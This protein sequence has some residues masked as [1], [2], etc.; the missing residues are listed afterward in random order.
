MQKTAI[1]LAVLIGLSACSQGPADDEIMPGNWKMSVGMTEFNVPGAT[2][3]QAALFKEMT[4]DPVSE[5]QCVT[6][7]ETK[8]D[9]SEL[10]DAF[11]QTGDCTVGSFDLT[12]GKITGSM[13]CKMPDGSNVDTAITGTLAPENF[14]MTANT[15]MFQD[16]LPGGKAEVTMEVKG[17]RLGD[18]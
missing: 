6:A 4:S 9:P 15:E 16:A 10:A 2:E 7:A 18:C 11:T 17:E 14:T 8:F 12:D 3:Q 13:S 5:E 1:T